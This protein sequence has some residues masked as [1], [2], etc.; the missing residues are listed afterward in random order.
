MS[1][2]TSDETE[3]RLYVSTVLEVGAAQAVP[4]HVRHF[5]HQLSA[6]AFGRPS[7]LG[8]VHGA[9]DL[10][11]EALVQ[12]RDHAQLHG[13]KAGARTVRDQGLEADA[14]DVHGD[15]PVHGEEVLDETQDQGQ[16]G[17]VGLG[18]VELGFEELDHAVDPPQGEVFLL[19]RV[20]T[21]GAVQSNQMLICKIKN[22]NCEL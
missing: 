11:R 18:F 2:R 10:S 13:R 4:D 12:C 9:A 1:R 21:H 8:E 14:R 5:L 6:G 17:E 15:H 22:K 20:Q 7:E 3:E 16:E 19:G